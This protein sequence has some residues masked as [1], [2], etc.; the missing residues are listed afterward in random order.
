L[1]SPDEKVRAAAAK[2]MGTLRN[3][4]ALALLRP[5]VTVSKPYKDPVRPAA[6][7]AIQELESEQAKPQEFKDVWTRMQDLQK[8][9]E[10]L[11]KQLEKLAKKA[12]MEKPEPAAIPKPAN[13]AP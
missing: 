12:A 9:T 10:D 13:P 7:K 3:P 6:E 1:N 8:K 2:A 5:L 11:E 4:K